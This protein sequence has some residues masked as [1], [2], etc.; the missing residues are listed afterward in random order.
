M[1]STRWYKVLN[2]L[3][4]HKLRTVIIV[5][6]IAV[7]L[8]AVGMIVSSQSI[9]S[10]EL[11]RSYAQINPSSGVVRTAELF[12]EAFVRAVRNMDGVDDAEARRLISARIEVRPN[13]WENMTLFVVE[14]YA[15]MRVNKIWAHSGAWPP[16]DRAI[17]IERAALPVLQTEIGNSLRIEM[18]N[19]QERTLP[20]AG[21]AHDLAQLPAQIDGTPYG[22]ITFETLEWLGED[23]GFN[24]LDL[25]VT[26]PTDPVLVRDVVNSVKTKAERNGYTIPLSM[27]A[28]PGQ[29]PLDD[30]LDAILLAMGVLGVLSLF[31]SAF[32]IVNTVTALLAQQKRQIGIMKAIGAR[33]TQIMGMYLGLVLFY[34]AIALIIAAP[35]S[36]LGA[37]VLSRF[38]AGLFN[39]DLIQIETP[40]EALILQIAVGL[41]VPVLASLYPFLAG[42]RISAAEAMSSYELEKQHFGSSLIDRLM[43]GTV[44]WSLR[45]LLMRPWI[46]SLRNTFRSKGRL[47]LT[48][49]TLTLGGAIFI[50][51]FSVQSSL[52]RTLDDLLVTWD[53]DT[54]IIFSRPY[55]TVRIEQEALA[56]PGVSK[57]DT[58]AQSVARRIRPDGSE[59]GS[60]FVFAPHVN[61]EL[62]A[63]P[64]LTAGRWLTPDDTNAIV[65][66]AFTLKD[67]PDIELKGEIVLK[68]A[69]KERTYRVVGIAVGTAA[70]MVY[71]NYDYV[72]R[73]TGN[74]GRADV[75][76]VATASDER[77]YIDEVT[78]AL[79][80]HYGAVGMD[81]SGVGTLAR[82][83]DEASAMFGIVIN[84]MLVMAVLLAIVGGLGLMGAMSINV[85]ERTRE[86][87][88]LR[89]I[90][91]PSRGVAQVFVREGI[92]IGFISWI[93]GAV[94]ALPLSRWL[95][96]TIGKLMMGTP[97]SFDYSVNGLLLWLLLVAILSSLASFVPARNASRLTVREVL[98]YE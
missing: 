90:G 56:V 97:L 86:I 8:F 87:G 83:L 21:L 11:A 31:L 28:E 49:I 3:W 70:P 45:R 96:D 62:I 35:L 79:E 53:F 64:V 29:I 55:R 39:F 57:A 36:I 17:L 26:D 60:I 20:I 66:T 2:D 37:R 98:A 12:D 77:E 85:L 78:K 92:A 15:E 23:H 40:P 76:L 41:I 51:V 14:D 7:G 75:A 44:L 63:P 50:A 48:L 1:I 18:P 65:V 59:S 9:L 82:E 93:L 88:I 33:T 54:M 68:M 89:A 95:S 72:A 81:V 73:V 24:E 52:F 19:G 94:L 34:G 27:T 16:P 84:L 13:E 74:T 61:S 22:Y 47:A 67:E 5:L 6:S 42:L 32:L 46:L 30:V 38:M 71:A 91:A 80:A 69:G 58:W 10:T 4:S 43:S 25:A